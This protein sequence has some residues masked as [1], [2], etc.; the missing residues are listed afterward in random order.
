[1]Q[2]MWLFSS[3]D[4]NYQLQETSL[5]SWLKDTVNLNLGIKVD[6]VFLSWSLIEGN[7]C[8]KLKTLISSK[9]HLNHVPNSPHVLP[10]YRSH[11]WWRLLVVDDPMIPT[12]PKQGEGPFACEI[13]VGVLET[14]LLPW[15]EF[16]KNH[17]FIII[18]EIVFTV[19]QVLWIWKEIFHN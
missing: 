15:L 1:M 10:V 18:T 17:F 3:V 5:F 16:K 7:C 11:W 4:T 6:I 19:I 12:F 8:S 13:K 14:H 9:L 2:Q